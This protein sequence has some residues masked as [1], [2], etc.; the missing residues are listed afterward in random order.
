MNVFIIDA[1]TRLIW[2][3]EVRK[4][5]LG[6]GRNWAMMQ[7]QQRPQPNPWELKSWDEGKGPGLCVPTGTS[8]WMQ[9]SPGSVCVCVTLGEVSKVLRAQNIKRNPWSSYVCS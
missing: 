2:K 6:R 5:G 4:A 1:V 3:L 8:H 7:S 9:V